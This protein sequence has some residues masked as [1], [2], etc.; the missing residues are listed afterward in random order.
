MNPIAARMLRLGLPLSLFCIGVCIFFQGVVEKRERKLLESRQIAALDL[1][2][3]VLASDLASVDSDLAAVSAFEEVVP[4]LDPSDGDA[5]ARLARSFLTFARSNR[6]YEQVQLLGSDGRERVRVDYREGRATIVPDA[7]LQDQSNRPYF[8]EAIALEPGAVHVSPIDLDVEQGAV[9]EPL[10]PTIRFATPVA[11]RGSGV[12][13]VVAIN[14][15]ADRTLESLGR[16]VVADAGRVVLVDEAGFFLR[17]RT[18]EEEWGGQ[19]PG[20]GASRFGVAFPEAWKLVKSEERGT[21]R[22][23]R[24]HFAFR[25]V[26]PS[27]SLGRPG[28]GGPWKT[29]SVISAQE[30]QAVARRQIWVVATAGGSFL[31]L[32]GVFFFG[33]AER[34]IRAEEAKRRAL[35]DLHEA[36]ERYRLLFQRN[37]A[38]VYRSTLDGRLLECNPALLKILGFESLEE[39]GSLNLAS[40][41]ADPQDRTRLVDR[42]LAEGVVEAH[43]TRLLRK[44]GSEAWVLVNISVTPERDGAPRIL[45]GTLV[46]ISVRKGTEAALRASEQIIQGIINGIPVSVFWKDRDLVF[47]GCNAAF[48]RDAGFADPEDIIGKDD[49]QMGWRA[50]ADLYRADDRQ[51]IESG[52]SKVLI[53]EPQ[54]TPEGHTITLLTSKMPLRSSTG[55]IRGVLGMYIDISARKRTEEALRASETRMRA[56]IDNML[57]G[58]LMVDGQGV[59]QLANPAAERM[60]GYARDE[61]NGKPIR[62]LVPEK[63]GTDVALSLREAMGKA[64]GRTTEWEGRRK[65][66]DVFP[67]ELAL[68]QF[69]TPEGR[70]IAGS[71][72]DVTQRREV[73]QLKKEFVS[74]VSHELRTPLTSIRGSLGLLRSGAV[75]ALSADAGD[76]VAVAERNVIRLIGLINDILDVERLEDGRIEFHLASVLADVVT[77]RAV[78]AIHSFAEQHEISLEVRPSG[79]TVRADPDRLSQVLVNL[80]SNAV[81]FSPRGSGVTVSAKALGDMAEFRVV[82]RGRGVPAALHASIFERF[83]QVE[84]GDQREKGGTGL[85]LAICKAIVEQHGGAIGVESEAGQGAAFWF[86][87]PLAVS[88]RTS[89]ATVTEKALLVALVVDDDVELLAVLARQLGEQG[90]EVRSA[91]SVAGALDSVHEM[92][93]DL[94]VLDLGLPDGDGQRVVDVLQSEPELSQLPLL[95]FTARDLT[96]RDR[97]SLVLGP[98]RHLTKS[99]ATDEEVVRAAMELIQAGHAG[100]SSGATGSR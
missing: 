51:V 18:R 49:Y 41:Y 74:T 63:H 36:E 98:T 46:D 20:R 23:A 5:R 93:P 8:S 45:E 33:V 88:A 75:G 97:Q 70:R 65:N 15:L 78:E 79:L 27:S 57:A 83:R 56:L 71:F 85:G 47:L 21:V 96:L 94:L 86:R 66:G 62:T 30:A 64:M 50:Q 17:G 91:T 12:R 32:M 31:V 43:E 84:A 54:T 68:F 3:N 28:G 7:E 89:T 59:I 69:E 76:L 73:E 1:A 29:V 38:G 10:T 61:L 39:L 37:L 24:G 13:G 99:K 58:L 35:E 25:T 100:R 11:D 55:E 67:F 14:Y 4:A 48:A 26:R 22:T 53:E 72:V 9:A 16:A 87:V 81:K 82:D 90:I 19:L 60:F 77:A 34:Q 6:V 2:T 42:L 40:L 95:V 44:D 52:C 92:K 80:I